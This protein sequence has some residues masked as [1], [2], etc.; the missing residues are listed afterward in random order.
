[1]RT[2][3]LRAHVRADFFFVCA[4]ACG[5]SVFMIA[6]VLSSTGQCKHQHINASRHTQRETPN[7]DDEAIMAR[8]SVRERMTKRRLFQSECHGKCMELA[9]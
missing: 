1:V 2:A 4:C 9:L 3:A 8:P 7:L 5:L 6:S